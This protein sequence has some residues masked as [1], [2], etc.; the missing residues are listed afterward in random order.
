MRTY[1][2][3]TAGST[4]TVT[5]NASNMTHE[6]EAAWSGTGQASGSNNETYTIDVAAGQSYTVGFSSAG[7]LG[8]YDFDVTS[9][10]TVDPVDPSADFDSNSLID[11]FDFLAWQRGF[12]TVAPSAVKSDG[13]ADND[14]DVDASDL[15]VWELQYGTTAPIVA[16]A[17]ALIAT[18][19][20][21]TPSPVSVDLA[22]VALAVAQAEEADG[23]SGKR[24][25]VAHSPP[26]GFFTAGPIRQSDSVSGLSISSSAAT[27][28]LRDDESQS[29]EESRPSRRRAGWSYSRASW[30]DANCGET[31]S[32]AIR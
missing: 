14:T 31:R 15:G 23:A 7:G 28:T 21:T 10:P 24:E 17:S 25:F 9:E 2:T 5:V 11:G 1:F 32:G 30:S 22:D 29:P 19:P 12:G 3:F 6:L 20:T 16:A 26:L 13:D 4:G 27:S 18:E 8:Y